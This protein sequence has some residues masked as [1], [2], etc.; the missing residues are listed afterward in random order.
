MSG[1]VKGLDKAVQSMELQKVWELQAI[2]IR[3]W[4]QAILQ[5]GPDYNGWRI[6]ICR[7]E[8]MYTKWLF[9]QLDQYNM[10]YIQIHSNESKRSNANYFHHKFMAADM[11]KIRKNSCETKNFASIDCWDCLP[12]VDQ[13]DCQCIKILKSWPTIISQC[14]IYCSLAKLVIAIIHT[15]TCIMK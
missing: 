5:C 15:A 10:L 9:W 2:K 4:F 8:L 14:P 12:K 1:V 6:S 13:H 11:Q 7:T 3:P